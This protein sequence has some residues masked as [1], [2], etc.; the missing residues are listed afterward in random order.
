MFSPVCNGKVHPQ[1][2]PSLTKG[3]HQGSKAGQDHGMEYHGFCCEGP[4]LHGAKPLVR[5]LL[6][7][8]SACLYE[9]W[10]QLL[11]KLLCPEGVWE[12]QRVWLAVQG[13]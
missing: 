11:E 2:P 12:V 1:P 4:F 6:H 8:G 9:P 10:W 13:T 3:C 5:Q 7:K